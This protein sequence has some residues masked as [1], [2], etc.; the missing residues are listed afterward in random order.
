MWLYRLTL[1]TLTLAVPSVAFAASQDFTVTNHT[2][3]QI[4]SIYVGEAGTNIL[5][6][7]VMGRDKL[8]SGERVA[9]TFDRDT[10]VCRYDLTIKYH[11]STRV[12]FEN[13]NVCDIEV[14]SLYWN[15]QNHSTI[16]TA[17]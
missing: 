1:A 14:V 4:D 17:K 13:L 9:I 5:G 15:K 16:S 10:K 11:D 7:D 3:Y 6:N 12:T 8:E 2:Q